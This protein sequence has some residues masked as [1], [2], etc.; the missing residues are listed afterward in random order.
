MLLLKK[1]NKYFKKTRTALS[2][3]CKQVDDVHVFS[4]WLHHLRL[5]HQIQDFLF[6]RILCETITSIV[7]KLYCGK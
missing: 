3:D 7:F 1:L 2:A 4:D 6:T 5:W